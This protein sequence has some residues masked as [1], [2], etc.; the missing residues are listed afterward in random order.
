[1]FKILDSSS[2]STKFCFIPNLL[3]QGP[4]WISVKLQVY[5]LCQDSFFKYYGFI[6][7]TL[8]S[9]SLPQS[10][11]PQSW[12]HIKCVVTL[13]SEKTPIG[14][15]PLAWPDPICLGI[16]GMV[17]NMPTSL[18]SAVAHSVDSLHLWK[19]KSPTSFP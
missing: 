12:F 6:P 19:L 7:K 5:L 14:Q 2:F 1:M 16:P 9:K 18:F 15:S 13:F 3:F 4:R 8:Q 10:P 11:P 17:R